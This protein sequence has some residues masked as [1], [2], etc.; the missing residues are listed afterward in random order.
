MIKP[1]K[2]TYPITEK[3]MARFLGKVDQSDDCWMW[4]ACKGSGGC[5][6]FRIG[7]EIVRAHRFA[8]EAFVGSI[9]E[10]LLVCHHCDNP[11]CVNPA[12]LFAGTN[13]DNRQD[14]VQKGRARGGTSGPTT[15]EGRQ[16]IAEVSAKRLRDRWQDPAYR[17]Y[18]IEV[19]QKPRK[20]N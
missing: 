13:D 8:Y 20:R 19:S 7:N 4:L 5:G 6:R 2:R 15:I 9:P 1:R 3:I 17:A 10:D 11:P 12:H 14:S 16:H 18:M